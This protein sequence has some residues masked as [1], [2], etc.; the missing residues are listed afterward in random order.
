[1]IVWPTPGW[2]VFTAAVRFRPQTRRRRNV[3]C[4]LGR[5]LPSIQAH[6]LSIIQL[7]SRQTLWRVLG[8][9][10]HKRSLPIWRA[11]LMDGWNDVEKTSS[12]IRTWWLN[13]FWISC[14]FFTACSDIILCRAV[15]MDRFYFPD[16]FPAFSQSLDSV[17]FSIIRRFEERK[18][19]PALIWAFPI[20]ILMTN[21]TSICRTPLDTTVIACRRHIH[22]ITTTLRVNITEESKDSQSPLLLTLLRPFDVYR[23]NPSDINCFTF[24][25]FFDIAFPTEVGYGV[26]PTSLAHETNVSCQ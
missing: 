24:L 2:A 17:T 21:F 22:R 26:P 15:P 8:L 12:E 19:P 4:W 14:T 16:V 20:E 1:M 10:S 11:M 9:I 6:R 7:I 3:C 5:P 18:E 23:W 25:F 13:L